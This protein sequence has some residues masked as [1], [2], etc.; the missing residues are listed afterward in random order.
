MK[1]VFNWTFTDVV[2]FLKEHG[3]THIHTEGSHYHYA[4]NYGRQPRLVQVHFHGSKTIKPRTLKS[5][6]TQSGIPKN[7]WLNS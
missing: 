1:G 7:I 6:I 4:G 5:I 2:N 3:F